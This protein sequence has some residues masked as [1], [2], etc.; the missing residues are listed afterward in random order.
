LLL[1]LHNLREILRIP[2]IVNQLPVQPLE[3]TV[4]LQHPVDAMGDNQ[5][6]FAKGLFELADAAAGGEYPEPGSTCVRPASSLRRLSSV[7][8]NS[9]AVCPEPLVIAEPLCAVPQ[10]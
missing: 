3:N 6:W 1:Q 5:L 4:G 2:L 9:Q 8:K 7:P 10:L